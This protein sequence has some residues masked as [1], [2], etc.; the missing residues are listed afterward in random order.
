MFLVSFRLRDI[1]GQDESA[2]AAE[3]KR[4]QEAAVG[5]AY[6]RGQQLVNDLV[7]AAADDAW[8]AYREVRAELPRAV[9]EEFKRR[10]SEVSMRVRRTC[11]GA[12][13]LAPDEVPSGGP[14][15]GPG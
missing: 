1:L 12:S 10:L 6:R 5:A 11:T 7:E 8:D 13:A 9:A 15:R 4:R 3:P 14:R 2:V